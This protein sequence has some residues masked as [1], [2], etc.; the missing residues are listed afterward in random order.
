MTM[1]P[2]HVAASDGVELDAIIHQQDGRFRPTVILAHGITV[3]MD[4]GG[5]FVRLADRLARAGF[6]TVRFSFRGHGRS[7]GTQRGATIAGE[8]LDLDAF[9]GHARA[10]Y[11]SPLAVV[12]ASFAAVPV[13]LSLPYLHDLAALVLW[14]PVLDLRR[15]FTQPELPWGVDNFGARATA[16][17][18]PAWLADDR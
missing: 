10:N 1:T 9:V 11:P 14:N 7:G 17:P 3:D 15:T 18:R 5:M 6:T 13:A 4:E 16:A 12:A 8:M 2:I